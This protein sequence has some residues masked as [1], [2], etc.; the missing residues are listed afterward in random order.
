MPSLQAVVTRFLMQRVLKPWLMNDDVKV[1]RQRFAR[2]ASPRR[3]V[4]AAIEP[5]DAGGG[6]AAGGIPHRG[7]GGAAGGGG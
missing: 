4:P 2:L 6:A 5:V 1:T 3:M 7:G